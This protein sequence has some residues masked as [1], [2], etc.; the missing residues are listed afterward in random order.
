MFILIPLQSNA[1]LLARS[2]VCDTC[3]VETVE[4]ETRTSGRVDP[5]VIL[6]CIKSGDVGIDAVESVAMS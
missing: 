5:R 2:D 4:V 6:Q 3:L 1:I